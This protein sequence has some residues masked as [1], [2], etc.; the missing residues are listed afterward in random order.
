MFTQLLAEDLDGRVQA[1]DL[2]AAHAAGAVAAKR[3]RDGQAVEIRDV[4]II[5]IAV[6]RRA[7]IATRNTRHFQGAGVDVVNPW[8]S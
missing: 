1:F 3:Q 5:G 6:S 7:T 2:A 4:Q 8:T